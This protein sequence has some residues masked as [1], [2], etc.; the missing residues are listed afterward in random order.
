MKKI[1]I[2]SPGF[3]PVPAVRGG[4]VEQLITTIIQKNEQCKNSINID[5]YTI[6]NNRIR[7]DI[8][9]KT[10]IIQIRTN[11]IAVFFEHYVN[12]IFKKLKIKK[13]FSCYD[14]QVSKILN[15]KIYD[16]IIIENNMYLFKEVFKN[17]KQGT[18]FIFHLHNDVDE[19]YKPKELCRYIGEKAQLILTVSNYIKGRFE[20]AAMCNKDKVKVLYNCIDIDSFQKISIA[21]QDL[22]SKLNLKSNDFIF[23]YVGRFDEEKGSYELIKAFKKINDK[24]LKLLLVGKIEPGFKNKYQQKILKEI[25]ED[26]RIIACGYVDRETL[27]SYYNISD[28]VV[29]PTICEEAFGLVAIEAMALS[30]PLIITDSGGLKE[31]V[32]EDFAKIA[33]RNNLEK[34]L[35]CEMKNYYNNRE[36][37][38]SIGKKSLEHLMNC[39]EFKEQ[40]YFENF[41]NLIISK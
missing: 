26:S 4:G 14:R 23:L 7:D 10:K 16:Y 15:N 1:A 34:S 36:K 29:I 8:F 35:I 41:I 3:L 37:L 21:K 28:V 12:R 5:L 40:N 25:N 24:N 30:K 39:N 19:F 38:E 13:I 31:V 9:K 11:K 2:I 6:Y 22:K 20:N 27:S 32:R 17:Y 33:F 18:K